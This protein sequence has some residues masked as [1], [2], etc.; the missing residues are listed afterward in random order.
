MRCA[1]LRAEPRTAELVVAAVLALYALT[2]FAFYPVAPTNDDEAKYIQQARLLLQGTTTVELIDPKNGATIP[3]QPSIY[4]V[5]TALVISPF[6][7]ALGPLSL[8]I[9]IKKA[10]SGSNIKKTND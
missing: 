1:A 8:A 5:G 6:V 2:F 7:W 3:F 9:E 10:D 4:P